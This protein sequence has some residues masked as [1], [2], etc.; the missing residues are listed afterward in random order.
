[1]G[2]PGA[3]CARDRPSMPPPF[4]ELPEARARIL[5][6]SLPRWLAL[7]HSPA[8]FASIGGVLFFRQARTVTGP[9]CRA[10]VRT[11]LG[12]A[13]SGVE[14]VAHVCEN[15]RLVLMVCSSEGPPCSLRWH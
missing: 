9:S 14:T 10:G 5:S 6:R 11:G 1:M 3:A 8:R 7:P 12:G 13:G 15:D 2:G 4:A